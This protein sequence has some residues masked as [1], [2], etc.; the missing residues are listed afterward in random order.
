MAIRVRIIA[1]MLIVIYL[2]LIVPVYLSGRNNLAL[3]AFGIDASISQL[4]IDQSDAYDN[5]HA[6]AEGTF[7]Q[8]WLVQ[9]WDEKAWFRE[10][11]ALKEAGMKYIIL[12]PTAFYK[13]NLLSG[14]G[15]TSVIFPMQSPMQSPM[16]QSPGLQIPAWLPGLQV[17]EAQPEAQ[18]SEQLVEQPVAHPSGF[19]TIRR[20]DGTDYPD[21]V[22]ICLRT[23]KEFGFRVFIGLNYSDD[24][25]NSQYSRE[26]VTARVNEGNR[27]ADELWRRY[28]DKYAGTF[29]G[30]YWCWEVN[31]SLLR[32]FNLLNSWEVLAET[33]RMQTEYLEKTG[34]R[35]PV[36][37]SPF[38]DR[39]FG[40][41][42][43]NAEMWKYV[44]ARSGLREGDVFCPQDSIGSGGLNIDDL[45]VWF[46]ELRKSVDTLPGLKFW[47]DTETFVSSDWS[48]AP[49]N[50][51]VRQMQ[52]VSPYVDKQ[53]TFAYSHYYSPNIVNDGFHKTYTGYVK[54]GILDKDAP[55]APKG[56]SAV[57]GSDGKAYL[58]WESSSDNIGVC[59]YYV[60]RNGKMVANLQVPRKSMTDDQ[61]EAPVSME[62]VYP[63][64]QKTYSYEIKAYDFAGNVSQAVA[65]VMSAA[66]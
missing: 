50:R 19:L 64:A 59:G 25:W 33:L 55:T 4:F 6:T 53:I 34:K 58:K 29:Y 21:V 44:F 32:Q 13:G 54:S 38:M 16:Q 5:I 36:M 1:L 18:L 66:H 20:A 11:A 24:W 41:P 27:L 31:N 46:A 49:I 47:S 9:D 10:F 56:F 40:S 8:W 62:D 14:T 15:S 12:G 26:W 45:P 51:F 3:M 57:P 23:A 30:W 63:D 2:L 61:Q 52:A 48:G 65:T 7:I 43:I 35:L 37:L 28:Y 39:R 17:S 42:R 60:Y 22:D